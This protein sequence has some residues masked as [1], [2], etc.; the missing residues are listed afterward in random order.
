MALFTH[1]ALAATPRVE[2][3]EALAHNKWEPTPST[4]TQQQLWERIQE[5]AR[6]VAASGMTA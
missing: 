6:D 5:D 1:L 4:L 3:A 2:A